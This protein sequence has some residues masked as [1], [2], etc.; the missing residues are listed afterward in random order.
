M[1]I[2]GLFEDIEAPSPGVAPLLTAT[3]AAG[4]LAAGF[5]TGL[6]ELHPW[7]GGIRTLAQDDSGRI[8]AGTDR[9]VARF[10]RDGAWDTSYGVC[11]LA[12]GDFFDGFPRQVLIASRG[13]TYIVETGT[14]LNMVA[15][16]GHVDRPRVLNASS[17]GPHLLGSL[18]ALR[19]GTATVPV[20]TTRAA[21]ASATVRLGRHVVAR[22]A[23]RVGACHR[24][25]LG[26]RP[27]ARGRLS[28]GGHMTVTVSL[29]QGTQHE[30]RRSPVW[31]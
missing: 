21:Q 14:N 5:A 19:D 2:A 30:T 25:L 16:R 20:A 26:L 11:G 6:S 9:G 17:G 23:R 18:R 3:D 8:V 28:S 22:G 15:L 4:A 1:L 7:E 12:S 29:K 31:L 13:R 27:T 24:T 10:T